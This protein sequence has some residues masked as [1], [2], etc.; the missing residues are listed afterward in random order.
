[1]DAFREFCRGLETLDLVR[2]SCWWTIVRVRL[3]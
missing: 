1:M 2:L 3:V